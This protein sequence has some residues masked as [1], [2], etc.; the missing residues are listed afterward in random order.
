MILIKGKQKNVTLRTINDPKVTLYRFNI[1]VFLLLQKQ[2]YN[3][4]SE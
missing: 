1:K 3:H 2:Y 4:Y